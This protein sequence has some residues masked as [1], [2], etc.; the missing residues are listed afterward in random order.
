MTTVTRSEIADCIENAFAEQPISSAEL[1]K[2]A[3]SH[4]ARRQVLRV[5]GQLRGDG[6]H[7]LRD[8]WAE[9]ADIPI[10]R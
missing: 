7:C 3:S 5:L 1:V 10:E 8:L 4:G 9:L 2:F 6:Y